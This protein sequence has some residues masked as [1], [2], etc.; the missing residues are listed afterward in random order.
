[1]SA[2]SSISPIQ[3]QPFV[4][5]APLCR[6]SRSASS[7]ADSRHSPAAP[8]RRRRGGRRRGSRAAA[9]SSPSTTPRTSSSARPERAR[10]R[11]ARSSA[12]AGEQVAPPRRAGGP[13]DTAVSCRAR[14]AAP[15]T[16]PPSTKPRRSSATSRASRARSR[17]RRRSTPVEAGSLTR[18]PSS[19]ACGGTIERI[20]LRLGQRAAP[21]RAGVAERSAARRAV[22]SL[23]P[24]DAHSTSWPFAR[25]ARSDRRAHLARMK[26]PDDHS[27]VDEHEREERDRDHAVHREERRVE[28][29]QVARSDERVLVGEQRR[30][31]RDAEP[32]RAG[33]RPSPS[34]AATSSTTVSEV[35]RRARRRSAP[36]SPK[37]AAHECRPCSR[38][39][40]T[41]KSA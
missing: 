29:A 20:E 16:M 30:D 32:V 1:M 37:R 3:R 12:R 5:A 41:S 35:Q 6:G 4:S 13:R 15:P 28:A 34:P 10:R 11:L 8:P 21:T 22:A 26:Q 14:A 19:A 38:S 18:P 33:R 24:A 31:D 39:T 40:S 25:R 36:R 23:R 7:G 2:I 27:D 17:S 9:R